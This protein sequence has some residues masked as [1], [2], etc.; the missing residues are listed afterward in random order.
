MAHSRERVVLAL[1]QWPPTADLMKTIEEMITSSPPLLLFSSS[2]ARTRPGCAWE[3]GPKARARRS[4]CRRRREA[5]P[6]IWR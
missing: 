6:E 4:Y 2:Q 1:T 5:N 3:V